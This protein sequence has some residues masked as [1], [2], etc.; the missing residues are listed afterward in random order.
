MTA[1]Y[2]LNTPFMVAKYRCHHLSRGM[3]PPIFF[4]TWQSD[5]FL[6]PEVAA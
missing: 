3:P 6:A 1:I 4:D 2:G 5:V